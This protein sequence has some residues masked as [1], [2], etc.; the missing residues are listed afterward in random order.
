[1]SEIESVR[2]Y[3]WALLSLNFRTVHYMCGFSFSESCSARI[4]AL[5]SSLRGEHISSPASFTLSHIT[6]SHLPSRSFTYIKPPLRTPSS[7]ILHPRGRAR[8]T[9]NSVIAPHVGS[10]LKTLSEC[11]MCSFWFSKIS[12]HDTNA[13]A[14]F[15]KMSM[16][17]LAP[18]LSRVSQNAPFELRAQTLVYINPLSCSFFSSLSTLLTRSAKMRKKRCHVGSLPKG[19]N[20]CSMCRFSFPPK[21]DISNITCSAP[22]CSPM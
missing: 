22:L 13:A 1:M 4:Y 18:L 17:H 8:V 3:V 14:F 19:W 7:C 5:Q 10:P 9:K 6:P 15:G 21:N 12:R 2:S 20:R 16:P 11:I